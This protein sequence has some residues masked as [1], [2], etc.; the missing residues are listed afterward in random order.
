MFVRRKS[1]IKTFS[2]LPNQQPNREAAFSKSILSAG[3]VHSITK[4][5]SK[6]EIPDCGCDPDLGPP[7]VVATL[8]LFELNKT[9][10]L[11]NSTQRVEERSGDWSWGGCSDDP[12]YA[13]QVTKKFLNNLEKGNDAASYV[14]RHN[15]NVGR[16]VLDLANHL[17]RTRNFVLSF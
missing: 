6:G 2:R 13:I 10:L 8:N 1:T 5:C 17:R 7:S 4:Y 12:R 15:N 14:G 16:Q 9:S 3:L 11:Y